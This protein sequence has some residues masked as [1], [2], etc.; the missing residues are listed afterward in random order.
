MSQKF[1]FF[2]KQYGKNDLKGNHLL[3]FDGSKQQVVKLDASI[4]IKQA[5]KQTV[6][7]A[8]IKAAPAPSKVQRAGDVTYDG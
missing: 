4:G 1:E 8:A 5:A 6:S 3:I 2:N 7:E